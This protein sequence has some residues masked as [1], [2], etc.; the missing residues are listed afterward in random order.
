MQS[1][2]VVTEQEYGAAV[3]RFNHDFDT[4]VA[5]LATTAYVLYAIGGG[6]VLTGTALML[7]APNDQEPSPFLQPAFSPEGAGFVLRGSF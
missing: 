6:A 4:Q 5:P 1:A 7:L 2:S 3:D